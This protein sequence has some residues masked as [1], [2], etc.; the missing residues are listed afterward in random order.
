VSGGQPGSSWLDEGLSI[1]AEELG[2]LYFEAKCPPPSCRTNPAQIFP[3]SAQG[4][5]QSFLYDSYQYALRPDTASVTLHTDD[6]NGF[7]WRG[8]TW[9]ISRY[10][11]DQVGGTFFQ[12]LER[13]PANAITDIEQAAGTTFPSLFA[14]FGLAL[15]TDS[16]PGLP[17]TTA[18][19]ANR[20]FTRNVKQLW[21]RLF[22]TSGPSNDIPRADPVQLVAITAD[23]SAHAMDPGTM[24]FF[25]L[26]TTAGAANVT[27][28]FSPSGG[29]AFAA[30]LKPQLA[31][32][33]LPPG[34]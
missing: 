11:G 12:K 23:S 32:F 8:G 20:F 31:I 1:I 10:L 26:N 22:V 9:L 34:Q 30:S 17:R 14:N 4:F 18:P 3:D 33:R 25:R 13:G 2:S 7:A 24:S 15:Q 28:K 21:A 27:I 6:Q 5:V 16:F 19:A 29:G